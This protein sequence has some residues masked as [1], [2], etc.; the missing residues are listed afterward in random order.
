[1]GIITEL[2]MGLGIGPREW[3]GNG[4]SHR[5]GNG[6]GIGPRE[7]DGNENSHR[8]GDGNGNRSTGMGW[9]WE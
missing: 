9:E 1:M 2:G 6:I 3:D 5:T 4:N 7:W 8:T